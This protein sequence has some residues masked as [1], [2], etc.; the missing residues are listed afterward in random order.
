M[1]IVVIMTAAAIVSFG[2]LG[3]LAAAVIPFCLSVAATVGGWTI[4]VAGVALELQVLVF[5]KD[6]IDAATATSA[7]ELQGHADAMTEDATNAGSLAM[8]IGMAGAMEAGGE[9]TR[10]DEV[11]S[12][13]RGPGPSDRRGLRDCQTTRRGHGTDHARPGCRGDSGPRAEATSAAPEPP[14]AARPNRRRR[15]HKHRKPQQSRPP[16]PRRPRRPTRRR[17]PPKPRRPQRL[18]LPIKRPPPKLPRTS[19]RHPSHP[20]ARGLAR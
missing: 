14:A 5:I 1:A 7:K 13:R 4:S 10:R 12:S 19:R 3:P 6:L 17:L 8:Q 9:A 18:R 16:S 20:A 11:R 2:F 15:P